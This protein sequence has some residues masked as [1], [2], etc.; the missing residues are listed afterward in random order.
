M[1]TL[2]LNGDTWQ[3]LA[4]EFYDDSLRLWQ[5]LQALCQRREIEI[6]AL[7]GNHDPGCRDRDSLTLAGGKIV[8]MHGDTVFAEVAPWSRMAMQKEKELASLIDQH[9]QETAADR[10][11][12]ARAVSRLLVPAHYPRRKS[13]IARVWDAITPPGRAWRMLVAW[14]TM[15]SATRRF[16]ERYFPGCE[17]VICGHFHRCGIWQDDQVLVI[18]TGS[19]MPP[20]SA[21]W[22]EWQNQALRVG[23]IEHR[24]GQ[25]CR[26]KVL[27][28]WTMDESTTIA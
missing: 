13:M 24:G 22:C 28:H 18:N 3:E 1:G 12:M 25:W 19:F 15:V 11:A 27:G 10:F 16:A 20:G 2:V 21:Y 7:P 26:G 6:I 14:T 17:I 8:I 4:H 23:V 9:S 5:E